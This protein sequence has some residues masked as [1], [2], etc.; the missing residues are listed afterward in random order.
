[1]SSR[2]Q[3]E[4]KQTKPFASAGEEAAVALMRTAAVFDHALE[5]AMRPFGITGTQYNVLRILRGAGDEGHCGRAV[6]ERMIARVPDVPRLLD[7]MAEAGWIRRV[8]DTT[9]R[10]HVIARI[11]P[12][13]LEL[14][15]AVE[16]VLQAM[17]ARF[18]GKLSAEQTRALIELLDTIRE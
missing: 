8:R 2:I 18:V 4:L 11:T 16:P 12:A 15:E 17:H 6:G 7:R 5:E 3:A 1:M 13:G 10:R 14:V 9:D